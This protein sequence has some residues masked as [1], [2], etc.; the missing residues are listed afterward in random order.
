MDE[1]DLKILIIKG[2]EEAFSTRGKRKNLLKA[3]CPPI[4]TLGS[5]VWQGLMAHSNK[6]KLGMAHVMYLTGERRE[7]FDYLIKLG[8]R[9]DLSGM[10]LDANI[11]ADFFDSEVLD[12]IDWET[13]DDFINDDDEPIF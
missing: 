9:V 5:A 8:S 10:D 13:K 4:D 11:L 6:F 2:M 1:I 7:V 3:K 12:M